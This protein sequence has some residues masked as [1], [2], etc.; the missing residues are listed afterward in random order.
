MRLCIVQSVL[1]LYAISFF[2]RIVERN[3]D[4]DLV[5]LAD[6][7][8]PQALNQYTPERCLFRAV[9]LGQRELPGVA[10]RPGLMKALR[11]VNAD[12]V[13]FSGSP[14][15]PSQLLAMGWL[16]LRGTPVAMWGMFYRM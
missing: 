1:P 11:T 3:P 13:V 4:I 14:R 16:R 9:Q 10:L 7:E 8:T 15:E 6:L 5:V 12:V 2:N